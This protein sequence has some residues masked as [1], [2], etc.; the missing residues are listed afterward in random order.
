MILPDVHKDEGVAEDVCC[1]RDLPCLRRC[2]RTGRGGKR[3]P[4]DRLVGRGVLDGR[5]R[6]PSAG[7]YYD[8]NDKDAQ[9][10][11]WSHVECERCISV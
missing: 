10:P 9:H 6:T 8:D 5:I 4:I 1:R 7:E 3:D 2:R 11:E